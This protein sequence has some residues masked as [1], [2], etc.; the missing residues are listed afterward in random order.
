MRIHG[1][2]RLAHERL[3]QLGQREAVAPVAAVVR[4]I[5]R[6]EVHLARALRLEQLRFA[7][8]LVERERAM[9]AAHERDRAERAAVVAPL[10][11][12]QVAD[13]RQCRR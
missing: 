8:D 9:L 3:E 4:E 13:V 6:D 12:L 2:A 10:A 1:I 11:H 7:H 5:L